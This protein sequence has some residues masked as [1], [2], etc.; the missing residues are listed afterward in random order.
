[1]E[2]ALASVLATQLESPTEP[3]AANTP[4]MVRKL[5]WSHLL[6][7]NVL[8][9]HMLNA[10]SLF[11]TDLEYVSVTAA[12]TVISANAVLIGTTK[13]RALPALFSSLYSQIVQVPVGIR[14]GRVEPRAV[15]KRPKPR[16][17]L[18]EKRSA[19][20]ASQSA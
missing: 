16:R 3:I 10:S 7:Y 18:M 1:M 4:E 20:H 19:W 12:A 14:P 6:A 5:I 9:W 2:R 13:K 8:R 17:Y 11:D 15:K